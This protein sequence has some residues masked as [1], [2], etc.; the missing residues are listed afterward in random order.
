MLICGGFDHVDDSL[1]LRT[2]PPRNRIYSFNFIYNEPDHRDFY[3][4]T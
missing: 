3:V 2:N 1:C 4:E